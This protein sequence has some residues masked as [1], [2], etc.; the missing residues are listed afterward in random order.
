LKKIL[1]YDAN[2]NKFLW[3]NNQVKYKRKL[4]YIEKF[5][6]A[7]IFFHTQLLDTDHKY[8]CLDDISCKLKCILDDQSLYDYVKLSIA[9]PECWE[10]RESNADLNIV[11]FLT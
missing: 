3:L 1:P 8:L 11:D 10:Y 2:K 7:G 9:I 6:D 4:L 5:I